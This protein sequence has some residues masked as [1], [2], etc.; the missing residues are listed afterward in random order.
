MIIIIWKVFFRYW[1]MKK[2]QLYKISYQIRFYFILN[3]Y[4]H[5]VIL[6]IIMCIKGPGSMQP[7][8]RS[9]QFAD[10]L[11]GTSTSLR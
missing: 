1:A 4:V 11:E 7:T 2:K 3:L 8:Y 5:I 6:R 9:A 10:S